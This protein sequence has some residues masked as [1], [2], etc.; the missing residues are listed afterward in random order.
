M[1]VG[2]LGGNDI[3]K[4]GLMDGAKTKGFVDICGRGGFVDRFEGGCL[5]DIRGRRWGLLN[6]VE[7]GLVDKGHR[8]SLINMRGR[9]EGLLNGVEGGLIDKGGDG[10]GTLVGKGG[11]RG[12]LLNGVER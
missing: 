1:I 7:I 10:E 3:G 6:G 5:V 8:G 2:G 4:L 9:G 11:R 12:R